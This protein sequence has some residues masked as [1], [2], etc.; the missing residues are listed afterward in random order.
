MLKCTAQKLGS[1]RKTGFCWNYLE[2][3]GPNPYGCQNKLK[4]DRQFCN[5]K[6]LNQPANKKL[7]VNQK[8]EKA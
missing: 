6:L 5:A 4:T 8:E 3:V 7:N 1:V 2:K